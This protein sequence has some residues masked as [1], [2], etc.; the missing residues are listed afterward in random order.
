MESFSWRECTLGLD[1]DMDLQT[2][3]AKELITAEVNL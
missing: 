2:Q 1:V 3:V